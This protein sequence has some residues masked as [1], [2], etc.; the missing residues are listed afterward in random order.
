MEL[1]LEKKKKENRRKKWTV[2]GNR[3]SLVVITHRWPSS[4]LSRAEKNIS[5]NERVIDALRLLTVCYSLIT[6][7]QFHCEGSGRASAVKRNGG[8]NGAEIVEQVNHLAASEH[9]S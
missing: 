7:H 6:I 1:L 4:L 5:S 3:I 9:C 2:L 8:V